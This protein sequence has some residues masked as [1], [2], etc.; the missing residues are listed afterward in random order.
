[1]TCIDKCPE[2]QEGFTKGREDVGSLVFWVDV[3]WE[4]AEVE[5]S[6]MGAVA[7]CSIWK[8]C[9]DTVIYFGFIQAVGVWS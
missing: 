2:G 9:S 1:M 8:F 6:S 3:D 5:R 7:M 4:M